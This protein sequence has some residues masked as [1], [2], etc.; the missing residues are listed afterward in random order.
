M[1]TL[2]CCHRQVNN[3]LILDTD[4]DHILDKEGYP[5]DSDLAFR[6]KKPEIENQTENPIETKS[7]VLVNKLVN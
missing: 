1:G 7:E 6:I 2:N 3:D 5:Q 4:P